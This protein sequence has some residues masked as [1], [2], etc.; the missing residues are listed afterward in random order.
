MRY[1]TD[2]SLSI[3]AVL[4]PAGLEKVEGPDHRGY[5]KDPTDARWKDD[6]GLKE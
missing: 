4:K 3:A 1:L 2:V 5:G 6:P